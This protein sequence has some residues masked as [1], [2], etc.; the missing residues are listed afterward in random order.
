[1]S[2]KPIF[3]LLLFVTI[4]L[5]IGCRQQVTQISG[6]VTVDGKPAENLK[7]LFQAISDAP[8][9]PPPAYGVT[10][11]VGKYRLILANDKKNGVIP[12]EYAVFINWEDPNPVANDNINHAAPYK[13]P[14]HA[15]RGE[16]RY[17]VKVGEPQTADFHIEN[18]E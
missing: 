9:V 13:I 3:C 10:D 4:F 1:M 7:V 6:T 8:N 2:K 12:G 11:K 15:L 18:Q 14:P 5:C 17:T 16:L